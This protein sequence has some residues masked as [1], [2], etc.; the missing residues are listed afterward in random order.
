MPGR[1]RWIGLVA[2][3]A[4]FALLR[5][6]AQAPESSSRRIVESRLAPDT[7]LDRNSAQYAQVQRRLA[8]GWNTWDARSVTSHVLLPEGLDIRVGLEHNS[9]ELVDSF[10]PE[11]LIGRLPKNAEQVRVGPHTWDGSYTDLQVTWRGTSFRVQS[12]RD[13]RDLVLLVTP[14]PSKPKSVLPP[15]VVFSVNYLWNRPGTVA[16]TASGMVARSGAHVT[17]V[18][19]TNGAPARAADVSC[20]AKNV[21]IPLTGPYFAADL[22]GP[23]VLSTG[24]RRSVARVQAIVDRRRAA[25]RASIERA[26][27][28]AAM[29]DAIETTIGWDTTYEPEEARVV[30]PVSRGWSNGWGGYVLFDWDTFFA[31]TL[32]AVGSRDLAYANAMEILHSETPAG[33]VPNFERGN[34]WKSFDRSEPPVGA[35]TVLGIYEK[36]HERW[37]LEDAFTPLLRW[38]RWWA[39]HRDR[40]GYLTWGSDGENRPANLD[41]SVAGKR[42][43]AVLESGL[44]N[45]PMYD[46]V[47]YDER[48]HQLAFADVGLMSLYVADCDALAEI[49]HALGKEKEAAEVQERAERYRAKL[50]TMWD[51]KRGIFLNKDLATGR[52]RPELSPTS[53]YPLLAKAATPEQAR[54]MIHEHLLNPREFWGPW[55]MPSI[56]RDDPTFKDQKYWRGRI[57]GP[58][59]FLVYLGLRNY[60]D[61]D[62][63]EQFA[64][65][66]WALFQQEWVANRHVHENYNAV[67]GMADDVD[68][69]DRF[70]HW[71]AL[72]ALIRMMQTEQPV[73]H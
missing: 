70:Y 33:F 9:T 67:T 2:G 20:M 31:A 12:A 71:G 60:P 39:E 23:V 43:G 1:V 24:V 51:D 55:V 62:V 6:Q 15:T 34:G 17:P 37:F 73:S 49:A 53:F 5:G 25:Y 29:M 38:N 64:D 18:F 63:D 36:F 57:W 46:H 30:T 21:T 8:R 27:A 48:T 52:V 3:C 47:T 10:L 58:L 7:H 4:S 68:S 45:S 56:S 16:H 14:L 66:S 32:A 69:S 42:D 61:K 50:A 41:D 59:N 40:D 22:R 26:G 11:V 44:D 13:G 72:L 65:K 19:C 54:R 28:S 35:I